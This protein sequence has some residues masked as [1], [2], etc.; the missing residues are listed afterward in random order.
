MIYVTGLVHVERKPI[1]DSHMLLRSILVVLITADCLLLQ[2]RLLFFIQDR[3]KQRF[4]TIL[5][6]RADSPYS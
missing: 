2:Q 1:A 5:V 6:I 3:F 4:V